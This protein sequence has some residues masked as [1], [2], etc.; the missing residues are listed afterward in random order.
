MNKTKVKPFKSE[1]KTLKQ[2]YEP[3]KELLSATSLQFLFSPFRSKRIFIKLVWIIFLGVSLLL[4][5]YFVKRNIEDFFNYETISSIQTITEDKSQFPTIAICNYDLR[6]M[7]IKPIV[8]WFNS[9]PLITECGNHF[10]SYQDLAYGRCY[11]FNSGRNMTNHSI[12]IKYSTFGGFYFSFRI[13]FQI[14]NKEPSRGLILMSIF[15]NTMIPATIRNKEIFISIGSQNTFVV[16]RLFDQK[17]EYPY[18]NCFKNVYLNPPNNTIL[19][20]Y[21]KKNGRDYTQREC[22]ELCINLKANESDTGCKGTLKS[23]SSPPC[24]IFTNQFDSKISECSEYCPMECDSL[25]YEISANNVYDDEYNG[26]YVITVHYED[27]KYTLISQQEKAKIESINLIA[28]IGGTIGLFLGF[29]FIS[30]L[31]VFEVLAECICVLF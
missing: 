17:L 22:F 31:E 10:E 4:S 16:K 8:V 1:E 2:R 25:N 15:N 20:D 3:V 9:K 21:I 7:Q 13:Q 30:L 26:K 28:N 12:P 18:N 6:N 29:S 19:I 23:L 5:V 27:L 11:R 24:E 14:T